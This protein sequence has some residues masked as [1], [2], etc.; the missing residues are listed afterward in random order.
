MW[1]TTIIDTRINRDFY[2]N[3]DTYYRYL[4]YTLGAQY[5]D[6]IANW[7]TCSTASQFSGNYY[8][9]SD[10]W[11]QESARLACSS[12]YTMPDGTRLTPTTTL[13]PVSSAT[14]GEAYYQQTVPIIELRILQAGV[15]LANVL[16]NIAAGNTGG[17]SGGGGG[18]DES[19]D[20]YSKA[21]GGFMIFLIVMLILIN[22]IFCGLYYRKEKNGLSGLFASSNSGGG[23]M[24]LIGGNSGG[25]GRTDRMTSS[26]L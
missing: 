20:G 10:D 14:A 16:N 18:G 21:A 15:R 22:L 6:S 13:T 25:G 3:P 24:G 11:S 1:D 17:G 26:L 19:S 9:C 2:G 8:S 23:N 12:A 5:N 4:Q 7:R